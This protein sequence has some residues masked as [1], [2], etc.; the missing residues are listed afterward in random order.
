MYSAMS[1]VL[2]IEIWEL[3]FADQSLSV[4]RHD[5]A[6]FRMDPGA[7][8]AL[9][10]VLPED[11]PV[12]RQL[13][14]RPVADPQILDVP[15]RKPRGNLAQKA[16]EGGGAFAEKIDEHVPR[17]LFDS[18]DVQRIVLLAKTRGVEAIR[19]GPQPTVQ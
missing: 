17:P 3:P 9:G 8:K 10:E 16:G 15:V 5:L 12:A 6:E 14:R 7:V 1:P 4:D 11:L 2:R 13:D 19:R 18:H